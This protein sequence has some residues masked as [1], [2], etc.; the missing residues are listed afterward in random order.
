[1]TYFHED[2]FTCTRQYVCLSNGYGVSI[3]SIDSECWERAKYALKLFVN[4]C[5][6]IGIDSYRIVEEVTD[7]DGD[8]HVLINNFFRKEN[9]KK[10]K[11]MFD[12]IW[13]IFSD[14]KVEVHECDEHMY[15]I[16]ATYPERQRALPRGWRRGSGSGVLK[17]Q[18]F[19]FPPDD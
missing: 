19:P 1:M 6:E 2:C 11:D 4:N 17:N 10:T 7:H 13:K 9:V 18:A 15:A 16:F 8:L 3:K 14:G 5:E 12:K